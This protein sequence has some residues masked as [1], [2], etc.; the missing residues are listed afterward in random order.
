MVVLGEGFLY[1]SFFFFFFCKMYI[2]KSIDSLYVPAI[3]ALFVDDTTYGALL[4]VYMFRIYK[5]S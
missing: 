3:K 1:N 2:Q 4:S 5:W